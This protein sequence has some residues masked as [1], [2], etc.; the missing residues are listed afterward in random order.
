[1]HLFQFTIWAL[2]IFAHDLSAQSSFL[3]ENLG[4]NI[5]SEYAE[6][7]P[8]ISS[9]GKVL[10]FNRVNHPENTYG[11]FNSQDV[12]MSV[13]QEDGTWSVAKRLP[14]SINRERNN[15]ILSIAENGTILINGVY[16]KDN[17]WKTR[18]ISSCNKTDNGEWGP[19]EKINIR[20]YNRKNQ[21]LASNA[22]LSNDGNV[23]L[24]SCTK[25]Y[26]GK[27]NNI[28]VSIKND[29]GNWGSPKKMK[30]P[31]NSR[32]KEETPFLSQDGNTMYFSSNRKK[33]N[34]YFIQQWFFAGQP[35][36][37]PPTA[38]C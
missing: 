9:D 12:W 1:M 24:L 6:I 26:D 34:R 37:R 3:P 33:G 21:G 16:Y 28:F 30:K 2:I 22:Y 19:A 20:A 13:L 31:V 17:T 25:R 35:G 4:A 38:G 10:Y 8:V 14:S 27:K 29:K 23:M 15:A 11:E 36:C 7:N 18:G 32:F 5:N